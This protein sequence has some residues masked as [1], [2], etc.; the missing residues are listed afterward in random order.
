MPSQPDGARACD[1]DGRELRVG[2][3]VELGGGRHVVLELRPGHITRLP[4]G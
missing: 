2:D 1:R 3:T 4:S